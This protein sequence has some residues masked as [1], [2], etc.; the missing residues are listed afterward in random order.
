MKIRQEAS[1]V[2]KV[3]GRWPQDKTVVQEPAIVE[4]RGT[5][6]TF[7]L[8]YTHEQVNT[9]NSLAKSLV[10]LFQ[11]AQQVLEFGDALVNQ[12]ANQDI[13]NKFPIGMQ[14]SLRLANKRAEEALKL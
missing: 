2:T 13:F 7:P 10:A 5:L 4:F 3:W 6:I 12:V 1:I 9:Q 11:T 8:P 14:S